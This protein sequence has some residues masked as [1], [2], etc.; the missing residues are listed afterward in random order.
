VAFERAAV[1][2][3]VKLK[4]PVVAL[5]HV[6][7]N[8]LFEPLVVLVCVNPVNEPVVGY[9]ESHADDAIEIIQDG[10]YIYIL[11]IILFIILHFY[12]KL[13]VFVPFYT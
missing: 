8:I 1:D 11:F 3:D 2:I 6:I 13:I 9:V 7:V 5:V 4:E 12:I 10:I